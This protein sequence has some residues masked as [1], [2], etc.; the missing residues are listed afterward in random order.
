M[1]DRTVEQNP[2]RTERDDVGIV[3][4]KEVLWDQVN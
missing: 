3:V 1:E 2:N 4:I